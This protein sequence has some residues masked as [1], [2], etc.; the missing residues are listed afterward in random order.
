M[1][2]ESA[3]AL[4]SWPRFGLGLTPQKLLAYDV[5]VAFIVLPSTSVLA[6]ALNNWPRHLHS[7]LGLVLGLE[8]LASLNI[9]A[10]Y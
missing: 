9:I 5:V 3:V 4:S 6:L 7:G 10:N 2:S 1:A 8:S